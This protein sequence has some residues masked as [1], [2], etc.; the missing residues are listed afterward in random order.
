MTTQEASYQGRNF[1]DIVH[2]CA[3]YVGVTQAEVDYDVAP[4]VT[5][6]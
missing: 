3:C 2:H 5:A 6:M 4:V 1:K